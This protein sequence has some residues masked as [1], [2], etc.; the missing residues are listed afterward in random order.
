MKRRIHEVEALLELFSSDGFIFRPSELYEINLGSS[1]RQY[2]ERY[3]IYII[4]RRP[5]F[6]INPKS[7]KLNKKKQTITG[8][9]IIS[10]PGEKK[11]VDF[12]FKNPMDEYIET[13]GA[14][15]YPFDQLRFITKS[16]FPIQLRIIDVIKFLANPFSLLPYSQ[17]LVEYV[18]QSFGADGKRDA[19]DRLIGETGKQ[20]HGSLQKVLSD[21]N[22]HYPDDEVFIVLYSFEFYKKHIVGGGSYE[23]EISFDKAPDRFDKFMRVT[24]SRQNRIDLVEAALIRYFQPIYNERYKKT[25]PKENHKI[26]NALYDFDITGLAISLSTEESFTPLYSHVVPAS[27]QHLITYP[28]TK[29][30]DRATYFDIIFNI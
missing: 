22:A 15:E 19:L 24:L 18:G 13:L 8:E 5:R 4:C 27:C 21:L 20:G 2:L 25:F 7:L 30:E 14:L 29:E 16:G 1:L 28:I 23:P 3:N 11:S 26:L 6:S 10:L 12:E 9:F 17:L